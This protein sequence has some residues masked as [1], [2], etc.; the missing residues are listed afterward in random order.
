MMSI[1]AWVAVVGVG[2]GLLL[3]LFIWIF[4]AGKVREPYTL[5]KFTRETISSAFMVALA[6][7]VLGW[8]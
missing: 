4:L 8:W 6:G 7:R 5:D 3:R 2:L 1:V